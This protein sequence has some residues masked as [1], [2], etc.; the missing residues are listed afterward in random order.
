MSEAKRRAAEAA[1]ELVPERGVIGLGTGSTATYFIEGIGRLVGQGRRL[2]GVP[3]S[4]A[5]RSQAESLGIPLLG[6]DE[7]WPIDLCVDGAD[8]VSDDLDLIKGGGGAHT[9]EKIVNEAAAK[10][11][12]VVDESKLSP[13]LGERWAVPVEVLRF[14]LASTLEALG[15]LGEA[16]QR[17]RDGTAWITD[18]GNAIVDVRAGVIEDPAAL[19]RSLHAIPGVVETGLFVGRTDLVI[20]A[21]PGGIERRS[22]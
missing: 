17:M 19:D 20:V 14:G 13:R 9:R 11:V 5:S 16:S 7:P 15:R 18:S 10:N 12:I 2:S 21:G 4:E 22:R 1:L 3:T 8:E 6:E